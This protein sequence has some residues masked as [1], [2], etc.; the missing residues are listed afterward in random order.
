[1][2]TPNSTGYVAEFGT[3][4]GRGPTHEDATENLVEKMLGPHPPDQ[5]KEIFMA[6]P[7]VYR[8]GQDLPEREMWIAEYGDARGKGRTHSDALTA[9]WKKVKEIYTNEQLSA[10]NKAQTKCALYREGH[11]KDSPIRGHLGGGSYFW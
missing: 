5:V 1:M 2:S 8:E 3:E 9:M 7:K 6:G 10:M 11:R 4:Q